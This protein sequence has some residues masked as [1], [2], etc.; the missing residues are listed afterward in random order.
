MASTSMA[1]RQM[2][3]RTKYDMCRFVAHAGLLGSFVSLMTVLLSLAQVLP[4]YYVKKAITSSG[5]L[6]GNWRHNSIY[7]YTQLK[8]SE[9]FVRD[10][11]TYSESI[12]ISNTG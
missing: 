12:D 7:Y 2:G 9:K 3:K 10:W 4:S 5:N 11:G 1:L 6:I 8:N